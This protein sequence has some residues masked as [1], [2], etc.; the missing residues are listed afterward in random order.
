METQAKLHSRLLWKR[1]A[2]WVS[3]RLS[4]AGKTALERVAHENEMDRRKNVASSSILAITEKQR[5]CDNTL[6]PEMMSVIVRHTC[7]KGYVCIRDRG[8]ISV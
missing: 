3:Q 1:D 7:G 2:V 8:T 4:E 6:V 5:L